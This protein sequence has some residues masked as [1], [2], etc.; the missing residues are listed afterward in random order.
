MK[1]I[2]VVINGKSTTSIVDD[3]TSLADYLREENGLTGTRLGCEH[4]VCGAC[5]VIV[6]KRP[7]RA[8]LYLA[9]QADG[10]EI[11]TIEGVAPNASE[12]STIQTAFRQAHALQCGFC[13]SGMLLTARAL[14][15]EHPDP[16]E[17]MIRD[18]MHGNLCRCTGYQQIVEAV[19]LAARQHADEQS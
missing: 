16:D 18:W 2:H 13:T 10:E 12:L 3:R 19:Q 4:G 7:V 15:E 9:V 5:T 11:D 14:L 17:E 1:E 6:R 8:C